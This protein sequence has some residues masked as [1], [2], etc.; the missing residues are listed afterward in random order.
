QKVRESQTGAPD[1]GLICQGMDTKS[2]ASL[3]RRSPGQ[4][5][6]LS[7]WRSGWPSTAVTPKST[8]AELLREL[9]ARVVRAGRL[10]RIAGRVD[11][12]AQAGTAFAHGADPFRGAVGAAIGEGQGLLKAN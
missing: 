11:D 12:I 1:V 5:A 4:H 2:R 9:A 7:L 8:E 10:G 3:E 6:R